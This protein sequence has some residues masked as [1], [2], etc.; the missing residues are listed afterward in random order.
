LARANRS[1]Y[2]RLASNTLLLN[3]TTTVGKKP[4]TFC[5]A[6]TFQGQIYHTCA[7]SDRGLYYLKFMKP[8]R[9][10]CAKKGFFANKKNFLGILTQ[11]TLT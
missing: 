5:A 10:M 4:G 6:D 2:D 11:K 8:Q 1:N 9:E 7:V 3:S